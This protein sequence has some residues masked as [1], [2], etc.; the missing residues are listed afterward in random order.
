MQ[1]RCRDRVIDLTAPS[2]WAFSTSPRTR[3]PTATAI[4]SP[5]R[6]SIGRPADGRRR[7]P[8]SSTSAG[9]RRAP[10]RRR[11]RSPRRSAAS[12]RW[13][14]RSATELDVVI[15]VDT[16][17]SEVIEAAAAAGAAPHQRHPR[18]SRPRRARR[19]GAR[20]GGS[21]LD[22]HARRARDDAECA[23]LWRRGRRSAR[24]LLERD[25][26]CRA[27]GIAADAIAWIPGSV[28]ARNRTQLALFRALAGFTT[29]GS[30]LLVGLSRKSRSHLGPAEEERLA[31]GWPRRARGGAGARRSRT[32]DVAETVDAVQVGRR[33]ACRGAQ[34]DEPILRHRWRPRARRPGAHD[35][36]FRA[37]ARERRRARAGARGRLAC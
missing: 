5:P 8:V 20:G 25:A 14:A 3:S 10:A 29:L 35:G 1:W 7:R 22:A 23:G 33:S 28:S 30:P 12:C 2:S 34:A 15:S 4:S 31:G 26:A 32:H 37:A 24:W 6:R 9:S 18:P 13:C 16:S 36:R 21:V 11:H 19:G 17:R 27:A